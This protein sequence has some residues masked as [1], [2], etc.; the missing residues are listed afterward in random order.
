M[1]S[2]LAGK[3]QPAVMDQIRQNFENF[4][5]PDVQQQLLPDVQAALHNGPSAAAS[6]TSSGWRWP[7][8]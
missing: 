5:R 3:I 6:S 1:S 8:H 4:F 2:A 7:R